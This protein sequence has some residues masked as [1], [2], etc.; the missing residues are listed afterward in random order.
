MSIGDWRRPLAQRSA[1]AAGHAERQV[2]A[3]S[4]AAAWIKPGRYPQPMCPSSRHDALP[5][6]PHPA[7]RLILVKQTAVGTGPAASAARDPIGRALW[8]VALLV[9]HPGRKRE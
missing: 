7:W 2:T 8:P 6:S 3:A 9:R 5:A 4:A 1:A